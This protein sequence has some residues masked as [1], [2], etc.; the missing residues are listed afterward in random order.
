M[1]HWQYQITE[2]LDAITWSGLQDMK[3]KRWGYE[4]VEAP[5]DTNAVAVVYTNLEPTLAFPKNGREW[6]MSPPI[7]N[8]ERLNGEKK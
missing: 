6:P 4:K 1:L 3:I 5:Y 7:F 8:N 2:A